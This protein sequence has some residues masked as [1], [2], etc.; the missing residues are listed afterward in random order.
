MEN[1]EPANIIVKNKKEFQECETELFKS[2]KQYIIQIRTTK[3]EEH[4]KT[5]ETIERLSSVLAN[6]L[7]TFIRTHEA[8]SAVHT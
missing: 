7:H 5:L 2:L 6:L 4:Q 1:E 8:L 3:G